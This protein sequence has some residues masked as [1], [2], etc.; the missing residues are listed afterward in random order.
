MSPARCHTFTIDAPQHTG[1]YGASTNFAALAERFARV[2]GVA[3]GAY[4][5]IP[6]PMSTGHAERD[7]PI[8][9]CGSAVQG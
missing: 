5:Y 1:N 4:L 9:T 6:H 7:L 3:I 2:A 8:S